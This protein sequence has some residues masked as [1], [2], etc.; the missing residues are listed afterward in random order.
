MKQAEQ[1][2]A[3][4]MV[5][6]YQL[7]GARQMLQRLRDSYQFMPKTKAGKDDAVYLKDELDMIASSQDN[8]RHFLCGDYRI[9]YRNHQRDKKGKLIKVEAYFAP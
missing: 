3:N 4:L 7:I 5:E 6:S 2:P 8:T 1:S 9:H